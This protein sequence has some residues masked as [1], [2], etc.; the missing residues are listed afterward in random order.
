M[1]GR[2]TKLAA[3]T[4]AAALILAACGDDGNDDDAAPA[5]SE[6][7]A[8]AEAEEPGTIDWA[9]VL[10]VRQ[11][12]SRELERLRADNIIGS[13]LDAS[14]TIYCDGELHATLG[15]FGDELRFV[16]I[17]SEA[18]VRAAAERSDNAVAGPDDA[19]L[20]EVVATDAAK[21]VRCWHR[22]EDVGSAE[23]HPELCARCADNV[24][25]E[26]ESRAYA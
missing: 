15:S 16:F 14:V 11:A 1:R 21:C 23:P 12:V 13:P 3:A 7:E 26:G 4:A 24:D 19:F 6:V 17:T 8:E 10:S 25:G 20:V 5:T 18:T 9:S 22:R 2:T